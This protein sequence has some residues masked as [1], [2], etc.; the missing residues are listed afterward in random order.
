MTDQPNQQIRDQQ[1]G[2]GDSALR[3]LLPLVVLVLGGGFLWGC[4]TD[5][6]LEPAATS[7]SIQSGTFQQ[8]SSNGGRASGGGIDRVPAVAVDP[9][10]EA[11]ARDYLQQIQDAA[12]AEREDVL[13]DGLLSPEP[14]V[15]LMALNDLE[16]MLSWNAQARA[17]LE[18]MLY[19]QNDPGMRRRMED[20]LAKEVAPIL[21]PTDASAAQ[22]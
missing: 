20:L 10:K 1:Q 18:A 21:Q 19:Y 16:P 22:Y 2:R 14:T 11:M 15:Q 8:V 3:T 7:S 13:M 9:L 4:G 12:P 5:Q 6:P 17:D